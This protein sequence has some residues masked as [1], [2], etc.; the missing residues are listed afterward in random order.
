MAKLRTCLSQIQERIVVDSKDSWICTCCVVKVVQ[1]PDSLALRSIRR[2]TG[3]L[4]L[5][6]SCKGME[7]LVDAPVLARSKY[8]SPLAG[9]YLVN[10]LLKLL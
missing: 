4:L 9:A 10:F 2:K 7:R 6:S 5:S 3:R 8:K 1:G